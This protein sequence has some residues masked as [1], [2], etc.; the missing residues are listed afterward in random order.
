MSYLLDWVRCLMQH[1][2][3]QPSW[4]LAALAGLF[5]CFGIVAQIAIR[6]GHQMC[7][8]VK[9]GPKKKLQAPF[10]GTLEHTDPLFVR[11]RPQISKPNLTLTSSLFH[12]VKTWPTSTSNK[13]QV[14]SQC[15]RLAFPKSI[16]RL[17]IW[18]AQRFYGP[19]RHLKG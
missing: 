5:F 16:N 4:L 17:E 12:W 13:A 2:Q 3:D 1:K 9:I 7:I 6:L 18:E 14:L 10:W 19:K 15:P 11:N 8:L